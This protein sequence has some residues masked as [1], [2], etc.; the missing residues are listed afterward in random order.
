MCFRKK[1]RE[2]ACVGERE[3]VNVCVCVH[4]CLK[5]RERVCVYAGVC[6]LKGYEKAAASPTH[7]GCLIISQVLNR[8]ARL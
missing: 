2:R 1:E 3:S 4:M 6:A 8:G 5:E 7:R